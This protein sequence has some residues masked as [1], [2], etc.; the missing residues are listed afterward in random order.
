[1]LVPILD[2]VIGGAAEDEV[3]RICSAWPIA[4]GSTCSPIS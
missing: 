4:A 1:M 2:E 3:P